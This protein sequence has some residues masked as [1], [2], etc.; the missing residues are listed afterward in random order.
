MLGRRRNAKQLA[1][2]LVFLFLICSAFTKKEALDPNKG[3]YEQLLEWG[4][5]KVGH[6]QDSVNYEKVNQGRQF[7]S[8]GRVQ[9]SNGKKSKR[10]SPYFVCTDC[11]STSPE[12]FNIGNP[13]SNGRIELAKSETT[14]FLPASSFYGMVNQPTWYNDDYEKKYGSLVDPARNSLR[15]SIQLCSDECS[16][17]RRLEKWE[18]EAIVS[19]LWTLEFKLGDLHISPRKQDEID[20]AN[21]ADKLQ[22]IAPYL[23]QGN[24][25]HFLDSPYWSEAEL[26]NTP[27][28]DGKF[29]FEKSCQTCHSSNGPSKLKLEGEAG[30]AILKKN[31]YDFDSR[32]N[33]FTVVRYGTYPKPGKKA[34]MPQYTQEK[35]SDVALKSLAAYILS[36]E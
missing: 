17:G 10:I 20:Q 33:L 19:Y 3:L 28:E 22:L 12:F 15:E 8:Q 25:A 36:H 35:M 27:T 31:L 26:A 9:F 18:E 7:I 4:A 13:S 16:Q 11:H 14:D 32:Y 34:Y 1:G 24:R 5:P 29:I 21:N 30:L 6:H 2:G 23:P